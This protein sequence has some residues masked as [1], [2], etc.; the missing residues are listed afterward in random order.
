M[1]SLP[2]IAS[3]PS[4]RILLLPGWM[5][6]GPLHWQTRWEWLHEDERV[7]Q[8]DWVWPRRGDWMACLEEAILADAL[9]RPVWLVSHSL[10]CHLVA[11]WAEHS[12][13][14]HR[15][16]GALMVAPPDLA[17]P[18]VPP[19]LHNWQPMRLSPLPF[20]GQLLFSDDDPWCTP[21]RAQW[22]AEHWQ[23]PATSVGA[24]GHLNHDS[25]LGDWLEGRAALQNLIEATAREG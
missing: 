4:P 1:T 14:T 5:N 23:V 6:S 25:G 2:T 16:K 11:A 18:E 3:A 24:R 19:Q 8:A 7:A 10:G 12:Q 17:R 9:Q 13:H 22:L 21:D 15:V 20:S